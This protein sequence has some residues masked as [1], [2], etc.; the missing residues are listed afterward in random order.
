M[1]GPPW[2]PQGSEG[3]ERPAALGARAEPLAS[4]SPQKS[5]LIVRGPRDVKKRELVFL[6]FR[7]NQSSED[8]S[9]IDYLLFSSFQEFLLRWPQV[10]A[11]VYAPPPS[12]L[13]RPWRRGGR[14]QGGREAGRPAAS[15][16]RGPLGAA[17]PGCN[18]GPGH[19]ARPLPPSVPAAG[20]TW[21]DGGIRPREG[22][23]GPGCCLGVAEHPPL[24]AGHRA[25]LA[26]GPAGRILP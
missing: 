10:P 24:P 7:L 20:S 3:G 13:A 17:K 18:G 5:A 4:V 25:E 8:F 15:G 22:P 6:Q 23:Q 21:G 11:G 26:E 1:A 12:G 16:Q 2:G 9:A 19:R 14:R